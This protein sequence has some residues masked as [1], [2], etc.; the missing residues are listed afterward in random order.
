MDKIYYGIIGIFLGVYIG[1]NIPKPIE[2]K[3]TPTVNQ[4]PPYTHLTIW[5]ADTITGKD[6]MSCIQFG[7]TCKPTITEGWGEIL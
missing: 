6:W 7:D 1:A 4:L 2:H 5:G 3:P